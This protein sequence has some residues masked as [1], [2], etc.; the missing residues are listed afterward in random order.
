MKILIAPLNWGLGHASRCIPLIQKYVARGN[1]VIVAGNGISLQLLQQRFP[2][3]RRIE[4]PKFELR[5]SN[6]K[7]QI[8]AMVRALPALIKSCMNDHSALKRILCN[9]HFDLVI[10]DNRF[11]FFSKKTKCIFITHQLMVKMPKLLTWFEPI[12]W[13]LQNSI[14]NKYDACWIPDVEGKENLSGDLSHKYP[15]PTNAK[16]I[17]HLSRFE[18]FENITP[19]ETYNIVAVV[20]GVE[21]TRSHFESAIIKRYASTKDRVLIVQGKPSEGEHATS[22]GS[23][24]RI[25]HLP[26][27]ELASYLLGAKKIISRSGY[28]S[29]M[30]YKILGVLHKVTLHATPGQTEQEYLA[31]R[32]SSDQSEKME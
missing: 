31:D 9:E 7:Q 19:N 4:L 20:S 25:P 12:Y 27:K 22:Q 17:G 8:G 32:M 23:I 15:L 24:T 29:I 13:K 1:E 6:K 10:S 14:I 2:E 18:L 30:D 16:F 11:G 26:D 3:L 5:Y 28:S 21:P